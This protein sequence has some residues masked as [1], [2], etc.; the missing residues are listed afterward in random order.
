[1]TGKTKSRIKSLEVT[2]KQ[3]AEDVAALRECATNTEAAEPRMSTLLKLE[4]V[5]GRALKIA[6]K[7]RRLS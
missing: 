3:L 2:L 1:M 6:A 5:A 7:A 4:E